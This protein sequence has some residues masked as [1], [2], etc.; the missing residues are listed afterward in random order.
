MGHSLLI[1]NSLLK[2]LK[3]GVKASKIR[4][5]VHSM[6]GDIYLL[7]VERDG[8]AQFVEDDFKGKPR[9]FRS[10]IEA[11]QHAKKV[12]AD[13]VDIA[14]NTSYDQMIGLASCS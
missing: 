8:V 5:R 6:E 1:G 14:Y 7:E 9:V 4:A 2:A 13:T 10:L 3:R 12:K 11:K